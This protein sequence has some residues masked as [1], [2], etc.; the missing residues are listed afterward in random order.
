[1]KKY[2]TKKYFEDIGY[3]AWIRTRGMAGSKPAGLPLAD[4][5]L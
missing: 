5:V 2:L 4:R 3:S 1:M